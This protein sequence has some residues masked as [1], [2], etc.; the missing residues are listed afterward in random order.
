M[1]TCRFASFL[2]LSPLGPAHDVSQVLRED[3]VLVVGCNPGHNAHGVCDDTP[4]KSRTIKRACKFVLAAFPSA[5][6]V[7]I[8]N[9]SVLSSK[10]AILKPAE[11]PE[12]K[13]LALDCLECGALCSMAVALMCGASVKHDHFQAMLAR[14][15]KGVAPDRILAL[16]LSRK[17]LPKHPLYTSASATLRPYW[18]IQ[19]QQPKKK[20]LCISSN[21]AK[22][23]SL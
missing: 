18:S 15:R 3:V 6:Y 19:S 13:E 4:E 14:L 2:R 23:R 16:E 5:K 8:M 17:G 20:R 1:P 7:L 9:A 22:R 12:S 21:V 11:T 10:T